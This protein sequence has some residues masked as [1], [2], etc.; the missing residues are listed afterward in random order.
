M[1]Y[2]FGV[3]VVVSVKTEELTEMLVESVENCSNKLSPMLQ[4][5]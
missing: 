2:L 4:C 3:S 5:E 1:H